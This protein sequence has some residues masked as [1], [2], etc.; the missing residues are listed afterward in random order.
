VYYKHIY[1]FL[2]TLQYWVLRHMFYQ[3]GNTATQTLKLSKSNAR[4][5][6]NMNVFVYNLTLSGV[7]Q[8]R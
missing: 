6:H 8:D 7:T 3:K 5:S 1:I 4:L 2:K